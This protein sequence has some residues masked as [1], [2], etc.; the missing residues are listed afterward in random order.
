MVSTVI[1]YIPH[2]VSFINGEINT[3]S[4]YIWK[5]KDTH[6]SNRI[7][8]KLSQAASNYTQVGWGVCSDRPQASGYESESLSLFTVL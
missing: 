1:T 8:G 2:V 4:I 6:M 3:A 5:T 7:S